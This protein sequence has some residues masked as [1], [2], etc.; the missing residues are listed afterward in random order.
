MPV[1]FGTQNLN[2]II[3]KRA[4]RRILYEYLKHGGKVKK[5]MEDWDI[6][7]YD[8]RQANVNYFKH[9]LSTSGGTINTGMP[10]GATG[11]YNIK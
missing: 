3:Y 10:S 8:T 4:I 9:I 5:F 1:I 2:E 11:N 6:E 7:I